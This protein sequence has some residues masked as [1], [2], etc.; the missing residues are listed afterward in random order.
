MTSMRLLRRVQIGAVVIGGA[1]IVGAAAGVIVASALLTMRFGHIRP[2]F[3]AEIWT[4]GWQTGAAAGALLGAPLTL[5][6]LRRVPLG[7]LAAHVF[8][9]AAAG[10][11]TGYALSLSFAQP[12]PSVSLM[13]LGSCVGVGVAAIRLWGRFR[14]SHAGHAMPSAG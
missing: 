1:A 7:R 6:L 11:V 10:G 3:L 2:S 14:E 5:V 12:R 9:A 4:L 13:L 8:L